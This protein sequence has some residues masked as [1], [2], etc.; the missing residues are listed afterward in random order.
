[1]DLDLLFYNG[2][3]ISLDDEDNVYFAVGIKKNKIAYLS[4]DTIFLS[5]SKSAEN[6]PSSIKQYLSKNNISY[7]KTINLKW[8][9]LVP[10]FIDSHYHPILAGLIGDSI[11]SPII[12]VFPDKCKSL[13]ELL[14]IIS[15]AAENNMKTRRW[16]SLMGY[17]PSIF[18][19]NR[20]P[21]IAELDT[22]SP[23]YPVHCMHG[24]GHICMYNSKALEFLGIYSAEDAKKYP[25][26]EVEVI[27]GKLTGLL[28]GHTHFLLWSK[29]HYSEEAQIAAA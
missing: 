10:G 6:S 14:E 21:T 19:E 4:K 18:S 29:V 25:K 9:S 17:E 12:N 26:D 22:A 8:R 13:D 3:I 11:D 24:G 28:R 15:T 27:D 2:N 7:K 20:H 5:N 23:N 1:M 16:V